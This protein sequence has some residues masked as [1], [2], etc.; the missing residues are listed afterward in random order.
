MGLFDKKY[1]DVCGEK[2][3]LLGNKKLEDA[4]LCKNCA[5]KLSPWF[6]E[7]RHS[8]LE[9]I[10]AQL[11]WREQNIEQVR[12]FHTTRTFGTDM[13]VLIDEG[14]EKFMVTRA[15]DLMEANPDVFA[16]S[17]VTGCDLD[18]RE[19]KTEL[20]REDQEGKRVSYNPPRYE[21]S[22]DF[23]QTIY[24]NTPFFDELRFRLNTRSVETG[25]RSINDAPVAG[26]R[27]PIQ[28]IVNRVA[29]AAGQPAAQQQKPGQVWNAEYQKYLDMS[30]Q[31]KAI[32]MNEPAQAVPQEPDTLANTGS[33]AQPDVAQQYPAPA[34]PDMTAQPGTAAP[35][36]RVQVKCPFCMAEMIP[37][38]DGRCEYCG[39]P[40]A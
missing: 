4:N 33:P 18:I 40:L 10:R 26:S 16:F 7:R 38:A 12:A 21:Y 32:L 17:Q 11:A 36:P 35:T 28:A 9:E 23:T 31:I 1:C 24:V 20:T 19:D 27:D 15:R 37:T 39:S 34:Q 25:E 13:K 29:A 6:H 22:Y 8:T 14:A 2:I 30:R 3:G 5:S